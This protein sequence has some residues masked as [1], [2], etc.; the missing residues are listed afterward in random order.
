MPAQILTLQDGSQVVVA[1]VWDKSD[2]IRDVV[3]S[4]IETRYEDGEGEMLTVAE[5]EAIVQWVLGHATDQN[6]LD[7]LD[8]R[9]KN[10]EDA[11]AREYDDDAY[12]NLCTEHDLQFLRE[13]GLIRATYPP[14][15]EF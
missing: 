2:M 15:F 8:R 11:L 13:V 12:L 4:T 7:A 1:H 14:A 9:N 5:F 10:E 3:A 6:Y